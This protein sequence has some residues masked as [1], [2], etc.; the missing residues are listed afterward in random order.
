MTFGERLKL[1][2][3]EAGISQQYLADKINIS[4]SSISKYEKG[5][6]TPELDT[7]EALADFFNV[8]MDYLKGKSDIKKS[9]SVIDDESFD[10]PKAINKLMT[11]RNRSVMELLIKL[12][13]KTHEEIEILNNMIK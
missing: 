6:R 3:D 12:S 7:F 13:N 10:Y 1:L 4:K 8:D 11:S 9:Y 2:R 5:E